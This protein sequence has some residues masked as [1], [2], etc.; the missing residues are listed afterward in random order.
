[1]QNR[2]W[3]VKTRQTRQLEQTDFIQSLVYK[4]GYGYPLYSLLLTPIHP[5][6]MAPKRKSDTLE[7]LVSSDSDEYTPNTLERTSKKPRA[8]DATDVSSSSASSSKD[9]VSSAPRSW[10]D[11]KLEHEDDVRSLLYLIN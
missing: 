8:S 11:V 3:L 5:F 2:N 4:V 10:R 9:V 7:L 1:M 6:S